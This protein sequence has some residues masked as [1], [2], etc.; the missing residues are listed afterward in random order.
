MA[1]DVTW[2]RRIDSVGGNERAD[3][4][5]L[6][7]I[8]KVIDEKAALILCNLD[9]QYSFMLFENR[10]QRQDVGIRVDY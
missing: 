10:F 6:L 5:P 8:S 3:P 4:I 1:L 2:N 7:V 9:Q